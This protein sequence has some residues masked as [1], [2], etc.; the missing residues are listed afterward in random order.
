MCIFICSKLP[1]GNSPITSDYKVQIT[2]TYGM[3]RTQLFTPSRGAI[4]V[5][6]HLYF[7]VIRVLSHNSPFPKDW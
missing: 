5:I 6:T 7:V 2:V 4:G 1:L 3:I